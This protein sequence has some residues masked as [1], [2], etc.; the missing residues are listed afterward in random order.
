MARSQQTIFGFP[1][2]RK[3]P[4][5]PRQTPRSQPHKARPRKKGQLVSII[6]AG[7]MGTA[8][9][10]ALKAAG[11]RVEIV[12]AQRPDHARRAAKAIGGGA[13]GLSAKQLSSLNSTQLDRLTNSSLVLSATPDDAI[14]E[15]AGGVTMIFK[16]VGARKA[17]SRRIALHTS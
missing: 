11:Y 5:R 15:V 10:L 12:V 1:L 4:E 3:S 14:A 8:L 13:L 17:R 2:M 7:R 16:S 9:G 6:G